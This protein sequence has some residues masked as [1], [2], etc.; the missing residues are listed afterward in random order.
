[1]ITSSMRT[2]SRTRTMSNFFFSVAWRM[3]ICRRMRDEQYIQSKNILF[4][5]V[6]KEESVSVE[7][8]F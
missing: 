7:L 5:C 6:E 2:L 3:C 8:F 1:M 4:F